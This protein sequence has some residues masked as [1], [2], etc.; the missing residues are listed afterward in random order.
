VR[1]VFD[2]VEFDAF[3]GEQMQCPSASTFGRSGASEFD[4]M[5]FG[6]PIEE[7][8]SV[9]RGSFFPF[10]C[11]FESFFDE[12][13]SDVGDGIGVAMK[14]FGDVAVGNFSIFCFIDGEQNIGVF[15]FVGVAFANGNELFEFVSFFSRQG[16]FVNLFHNFR[17]REGKR[18]NTK[19]WLKRQ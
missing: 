15:D 12:S 1:S 13:F 8:R 6:V 11:G 16:N 9:G 14:L 10:E 5:G 18:K 7:G 2:D 3:I 17:V 19:S 4:Q